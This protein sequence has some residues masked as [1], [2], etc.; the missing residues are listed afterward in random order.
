MHFFHIK[1]SNSPT[2]SES[3]RKN[4]SYSLGLEHYAESFMIIQTCILI[5]TTYYK[6][7]FAPLKRAIRMI[8]YS[9]N[10]FVT[11]QIIFYH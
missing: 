1:F 3:Q 2:L 4:N 8:F 7:G 5:K 6:T 10:P 9:I 11:K